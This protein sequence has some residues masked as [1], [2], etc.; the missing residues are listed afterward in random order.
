MEI[1]RPTKEFTTKNGVKVVYK[2]YSTGREYNEIQDIYVSG[3]KFNM[4]GNDMRME[5]FNPSVDIDADKKRIELLVVSVD[6]TSDDLVNKILDLPH[7][8][9]EE[10]IEVIGEISGKKKVKPQNQ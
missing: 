1:N 7:E 4:L 8:D 2:S 9:Y 10:I 6:N 3:M 5:G